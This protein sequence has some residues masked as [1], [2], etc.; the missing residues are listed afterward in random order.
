MVACERMA[1][2]SLPTVRTGVEPGWTAAGLAPLSPGDTVAG[3]YV[4]EELL[5]AGGMGVVVAARHAA[6]GHRVALKLLS[7][8]TSDEADAFARFSREARVV[9]SLSSDHIVRVIDFGM[10]AGA[11]YMVMDL[12]AGCDLRS[13]VERRKA[14]PIAEA[15]DYAIQACD[16]LA[17]AHAKGVVHRDVKLANLFLSMRADGR[18]VV[19][20]LDFGVSKLQGASGDDLHLTHTAAMIGSPTYMSPE[21]IRDPRAVD[22]RADI[23]SLGVALYKMLTDAAP[24]EGLSA[25][26][27]CAAIAADPPAPLRSRAPHLPQRLDAIVLKCLEKRP[28]LRYSSVASLARELAEYA[29]PQGK[30]L[31]ERLV[32]DAVADGTLE[33]L[34]DAPSSS[35]GPHA[36]DQLA[37]T[38]VVDARE[39]ATR[40]RHELARRFATFGSIVAIASVVAVITTRARGRA[41]APAEPTSSA[42][43]SPT[44]AFASASSAPLPASFA[45]STPSSLHSPEPIAS[46]AAAP[47]PLRSVRPPRRP[48]SGPGMVAAPRGSVAP[49]VNFGGS[50]LDDHH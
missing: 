36:L 39:S 48:P 45:A 16:G 30:L 27:L 17:V 18:R 38:S 28:D 3:R 11:P 40:R 25:S 47:S 26:A 14:L 37:A 1:R 32:A 9:A 22:A 46:F 42:T 8:A 35:R 6:L 23:W 31:A 15:V 7:A 29:S 41:V 21:Q 12:L 19:K 49:S 33:D 24:F 50:A 13:E 44:V 20:L 43:A 10:H 5:G 34:S 2:P 4:V